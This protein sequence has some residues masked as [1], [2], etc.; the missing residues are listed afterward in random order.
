MQTDIEAGLAAG[1][2]ALARP[3]GAYAMLAVDQR[4]GLRVMLE[5][6]HPAPVP[7]SALTAFKLD[8]IRALTPYASA[9][10][11][12]RELAWQ[13]ALDAGAVAP[14]CG[15][16]AAADV[17]ISSA[18]ELVADVE[19]DDL[20]VPA[21]VRAQGAVALKLLVLWRPGDPAAP[22]VA[23]VDDFV[24]RCRAAGLVSIVEPVARQPRDRSAWDREAAILAAAAELGGR[25]QDIYKGEVPYFGTAPEAEIRRACATIT[26]HVNGPWVVLS[27]GVPQDVFPQAVEWACRE[28]ASGF[29]A[30]RGIW[31]GTIGA[32]DVS[33]ALREDG[34]PRLQRLCDVVDR[35]VGA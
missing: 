24:A 29:L 18:D 11:I 6:Q 31:A 34:V 3:S 12:D 1:M 22:R 2:A 8:A 27:S 33:R 25:G 19:I 17:L 15:L 4:E 26:R 21:T 23:M 7:D 32:A 14:G 30:G 9:V 10:L 5:K 35:V 13:Q 20:V 28:G 16:I